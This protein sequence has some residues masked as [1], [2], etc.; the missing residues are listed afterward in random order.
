MVIA[1]YTLTFTDDQPTFTTTTH[2]PLTSNLPESLET[3]EGIT[4]AYIVDIVAR[5]L[6]LITEGMPFVCVCVRACAHTRARVG[7]GV[8]ACV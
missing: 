1:T 7:V 2:L 4:T 8:R 6:W 5:S 3:I